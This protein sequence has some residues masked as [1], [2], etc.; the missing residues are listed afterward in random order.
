MPEGDAGFA[1]NQ[2]PGRAKTLIE[3]VLAMGAESRV[4]LVVVALYFIVPTFMIVAGLLGLFWPRAAWFLS[5]G[6]KY[7]NVEPSGC[8][9]A[10]ARIGGLVS[11]IAGA[12]FR[13]IVLN[14]FKVR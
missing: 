6:W 8:A 2:S 4:A 7:K 5:E 11:L 9:L 1:S 13:L 3:E 14:V 12:V 10:S